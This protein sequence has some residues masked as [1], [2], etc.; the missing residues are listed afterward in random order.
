ML[1]APALKPY[2][3]YKLLQ[4]YSITHFQVLQEHGLAFY[5][6]EI[7]HDHPSVLQWQEHAQ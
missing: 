7:T 3:Y 2:A 4:P 6:N 1:H 5:S